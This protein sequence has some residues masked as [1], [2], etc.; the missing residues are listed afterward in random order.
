MKKFAVAVK[1]YG[2][3]KVEIVNSETV[4][5]AIWMHT[6]IHSGGYSSRLMEMKNNNYTLDRIKKEFSDI[7]TDL[8]VVEIWDL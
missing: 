5:G 3:L 1:E 2:P 6:T 8:D 4:F 7:G